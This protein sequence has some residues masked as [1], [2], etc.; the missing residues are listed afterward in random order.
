MQSDTSERRSGR[1]DPDEAAVR[2]M[3]RRFAKREASREW[4]IW[5]LVLVGTIGVAVALWIAMRLFQIFV[6]RGF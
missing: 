3:E 6:M 5:T 2:E 4:R 1:I